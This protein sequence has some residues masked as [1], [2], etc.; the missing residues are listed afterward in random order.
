MSLDAIAALLGHRTLAMTMIYARIADR[1]VAEE[2]FAVSEKVEAL[3]SQP[4]QLPADDE[5]SEMRRL[6]A[7]MHRRM[8]G[9]GYC[10]HP[11]EMDCHFESIC[12]SCTF[13][14]TTIE[15]RPTLERQRADA[16]RKGQIGRQRVFDGLLQRLDQ[17]GA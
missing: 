1:T 8:L 13:F 6:R 12:E 10:A 9:N 4:A 16:H 17:Q 7:E 11:V 3:Y 2:Y 14:V 5:G 15:F